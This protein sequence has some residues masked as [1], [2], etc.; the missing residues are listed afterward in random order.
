MIG[1]P[2]RT[3]EDVVAGKGTEDDSFS[4]AA[5]DRWWH[6]RY[7]GRPANATRTEGRPMANTSVEL[8]TDQDGTLGVRSLGALD[9]VSDPVLALQLRSAGV[10]RQCVRSTVK[11]ETP[12]VASTS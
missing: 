6:R 3:P 7:S 12:A 9:A 5:I 8:R 1:T 2:F 4:V 11:V 10:P